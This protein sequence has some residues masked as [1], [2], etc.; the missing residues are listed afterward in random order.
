MR[1]NLKE[2]WIVFN[3]EA[4]GSTNG[5]ISTYII[6]AFIAGDRLSIR[7]VL[8]RR[9]FKF[10]KFLNAS[11]YHVSGVSELYVKFTFSKNRRRSDQRDLRR[12]FCD[13]GLTYRN[14]AGRIF[15]PSKSFSDSICPSFLHNVD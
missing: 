9:F 4:V 5:F 3:I 2:N 1:R 12:H 7:K 8:L 11:Y 14:V 10:F 6:K 13:F 15:E